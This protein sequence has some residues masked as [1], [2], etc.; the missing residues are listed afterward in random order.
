MTR[1]EGNIEFGKIIKKYRELDDISFSFLG[2]HLRVFPETIS[3]WEKGFSIPSRK[4]SIQ[5][6]CALIIELPDVKKILDILNYEPLTVIE[7]NQYYEESATFLRERMAKNIVPAGE[8]AAD[9]TPEQD[10]TSQLQTFQE[11]LKAIE[12]KIERELISLDEE[13]EQSEI[14][15]KLSEIRASIEE[16]QSTSQQLTAPVILP[17]REDIQVSLASATSLKRLEEYRA[18]ENKW[19]SALF[20]FIGAIFG[21]LINVVTGGEMTFNAWIILG[22]FFTMAIYTGWSAI[23]YRIRASKLSKKILGE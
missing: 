19:Y 11:S 16:I 12:E 20:L 3:E 21:V 23:S 2:D 13:E 15:D 9:E 22:V 14:V 1:I 17:D 6:A 4:Q 18:E 5:L 10:V 7:E 8:Q